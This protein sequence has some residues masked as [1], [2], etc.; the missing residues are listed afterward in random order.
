MNTASFRY[1]FLQV[2]RSGYPVSLDD[3]QIKPC[4]VFVPSCTLLFDAADAKKVKHLG[5]TVGLSDNF[6]RACKKLHLP[7]EQHKLYREWLLQTGTILYDGEH[8]RLRGE[9]SSRL[10]AAN[11]FMSVYTLI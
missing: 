2:K 1:M 8:Q 7:F 11:L 5:Y 10:E 6:V 9:A 3:I 4:C